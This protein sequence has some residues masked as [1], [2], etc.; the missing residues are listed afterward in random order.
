LVS[1]LLP[2]G[3][4]K[5]IQLKMYQAM[6]QNN[7]YL[8]VMDL[9][10]FMKYVTYSNGSKDQLNLILIERVENFVNHETIHITTNFTK[11]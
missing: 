1:E 9:S 11:E 3:D 6:V 10:E 7:I 2:F 4:W 8:N 5:K